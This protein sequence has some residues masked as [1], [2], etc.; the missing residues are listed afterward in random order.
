M[1]YFTTGTKTSLGEFYGIDG[2]ASEGIAPYLIVNVSEL[3][4]NKNVKNKKII[5]SSAFYLSLFYS[6]IACLTF[7]TLISLIDLTYI[8]PEKYIPFF[9]S[10]YLSVLML[11][12]FNY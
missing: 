11:I 6:F 1:A 10:I 5:S 12:L 4:L 7:I 8:F 2:A 9:R 3:L